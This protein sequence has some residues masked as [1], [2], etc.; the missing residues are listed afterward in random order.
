MTNPRAGQLAEA[1]E[2]LLANDWPGAHAL[3]QDLDD[4]IA[5]RVHGLVHRV[6]GDL[7]NAGYWYDKAGVTMDAAR[8]VQRAARIPGTWRVNADRCAPGPARFAAHR[9]PPCPAALCWCASGGDPSKM[10]REAASGTRT[11][12]RLVGGRFRPPSASRVVGCSN[13]K[14]PKFV[15]SFEARSMPRAKGGVQGH[16]VCRRKI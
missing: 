6:E 1:I 3:V 10:I 11:I 5:W 2:R 4:P 13:C 16:P 7:G 9:L 15:D 12:G 8:S 14:R